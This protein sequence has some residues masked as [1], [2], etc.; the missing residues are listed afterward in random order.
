M[1]LIDDKVAEFEWTL[2]VNAL[3]KVRTMTAFEL[4]M[5]G[6]HWYTQV[7]KVLNAGPQLQMLKSVFRGIW[8]QQIHAND[9]VVD[10]FVELLTRLENIQEIVVMVTSP[11]A[12]SDAVNY[13]LELISSKFRGDLIG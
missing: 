11:D 1:T 10:I 7:L 13:A 5:Q 3:S 2:F 9:E 8:Y 6:G 12:I 4:R